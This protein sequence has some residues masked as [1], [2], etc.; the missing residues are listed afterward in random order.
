MKKIALR[1]LSATLAL[2]VFVAGDLQAQ[3]RVSG[4]VVRLDGK[5][6]AAATVE[7]LPMLPGFAAGRNRLEGREVPPASA[8]TTDQH[9][10]FTLTAPQEGVYRVRAA[11]PGWVPMQSGLLPLVEE[12]ELPP[13]T[14]REDAGLSLRLIDSSGSPPAAGL[15]VLAEPAGAAGK[16][17]RIAPWQ[18]DV[19]IR[20]ADRDGRVDLP[21]FAGERLAVTWFETGTAALG[22]RMLEMPERQAT[23]TL[24]ASAGAPRQVRI[25]DTEGRALAGLLLRAGPQAWPVGL[26]DEQGALQLRGWPEHGLELRVTDPHGFSTSR[27]G[28][29]PEGRPV[30]VK[31]EGSSPFSG[32]VYDAESG[33]P[34]AGALIWLPA[35][36]GSLVRSGVDGRF[37]HRAPEPGTFWL[38][39]VAPG[40]LSKRIPVSPAGM[41]SDR[42]LAIALTRAGRIRGQVVDPKGVPV[43][44]AWVDAELENPG[45]RPPSSGIEA[46][47][48]GGTSDPGGA[49]ELR[50][51]RPG[52]GYTLR[53]QRPGYLT[54]TASAMAPNLSLKITLQPPP[55]AFGQVRDLQGLPVAGAEVNVAPK[56]PR[57]RSLPDETA[58]L[59][60][61]TDEHGLFAFAE[62]PAAEVDLVVSKAGFASA[63]FRSLQ[64]PAGRPAVDLG[65]I[66]LRPGATVRGRILDSRKLPVAAARI[67]QVED[68]ARTEQL[69]AALAEKE[70]DALSSNRGDFALPDRP[71]GSTIHLLILAE[72]YR[73]ESLRGARVPT[74]EPL[75]VTLTKAFAARGR[76]LDENG[77]PVTGARVE[78]SWQEA[79]AG[80]QDRI[81]VGMEVSKGGTTDQEGRFKLAGLPGGESDL[82]IL[83]A[84]FLPIENQKLVLPPAEPATEPT[85]VLKRGA[86]LE[87]RV[88]T[89]DGSPVRG[90][91]I[92]AGTTGA[93]LTDDEGFYDLTGV[94]PGEAE[95]ELF[96]PHFSRQRKRQTLAAGLNRLDFQ[97]PAGQEVRGQVL[98]EERRPVPGARVVLRLGSRMEDYR[99]HRA[100][101]AP[102]GSFRL[103]P[104]A[105]GRYLLGAM[106]E[107]YSE[108][109]ARRPVVVAGESVEGLEVILPRGADLVGRVAGLDAE[110]LWRLQVQAT[111][112]DGRSHPAK[113]DT[114][115]RYELRAL[116]LGGWQLKASLGNGERQAQARAELRHGGEVVERDLKFEEG[117]RLS[118][119][120]LFQD[121]PLPAAR[122]ALRADRLAVERAV[123]TDHQGRFEIKDLQ[124]DTY[125]LGI[126]HS[127][128]LVVYNGKLALAADRDLVLDLK[129]VNVHGTI[130]DTATDRPIPG[131][132]VS[133]E[134]Q[135]GPETSEFLI[136]ASTDD[137]GAFLLPRVPPGR[138]RLR[139]RAEGYVAREE[140][141][142]VP[143]QDELS[144]LRLALTPTAGLEV[145][146]R[147][148]SGR[149]PSIVHFRAVS[150]T[151]AAVINGSQVPDPEGRVRLPTPAKGSWLLLVGAPGSGAVEV[152]AQTPGPPVSVVLPPSA[153]L[154]VQVPELATAD[155]RAEVTVSSLDGSLVPILGPGGALRQTWPMI[156]GKTTI[157]D[158]PAGT[159][160]VDASAGDGRHWSTTVVAPGAASVPVVLE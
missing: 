156:G 73:P 51:L 104:V 33:R 151:D 65:R 145:V 91:R 123:L 55:R 27:V 125:W 47:G 68:P 74:P 144:G 46:V 126:S 143:A 101:S 50:R 72:G 6:F 96:H 42:G 105:D 5:P 113:L 90:A 102:D 2:A 93:A 39:A 34:L 155:V 57:S 95:V 36:P 49:F 22:T 160:I 88:T 56:A 7:L 146:A 158:L 38:E 140:G 32:R 100:R 81:P 149:I 1:L 111:G 26:T 150:T 29:A 8:A 114:D 99:E 89:G 135:P 30:T 147:L 13:V 61:A 94:P 122:V 11:A 62:M 48:D 52:M 45:D 128:Q 17:Q 132:I 69:A 37:Q 117:L 54:T 124:P 139:G 63:T 79:L 71:T 84:G 115:G 85:F 4:S 77:E 28:G 129:G 78:L 116:P 120:I 66:V 53:V 58:V 130:V 110:D 82:S 127:R 18:P 118:G 43:A 44:G 112:E 153:R 67:Y 40:Y 136:A 107:G 86:M 35:D 25:V 157:E 64:L 3:P 119:R 98:D 152:P 97:L 41:R 134:H 10:R 21:R 24:E 133:L 76:V 31:V 80:V 60:A 109:K 9:G 23:L 83:A 154:S 141:V 14:L 20:R 19:R 108:G 15:W 70:P 16:P 148:A 87:G 159:W 92:D 138:Y 103:Q 59:H 12:T 106:A 121:E 75:A 137:A 142:E 131:A